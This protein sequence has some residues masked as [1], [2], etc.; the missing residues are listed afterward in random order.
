MGV[1]LVGLSRYSER[2]P[3]LVEFITDRTSAPVV[4]RFLGGDFLQVGFIRR[5]ALQ[6]IWRIRHYDATV[7][8]AFL[9]GLEDPYYEVRSWTAKAICRMSESVGEDE[10]I[11][12]LLRRNLQDRWFEVIVESA[13][14]LGKIACDQGIF[15][16][17]KVLLQHHNW[18]VR[19]AALACLTDL[20]LRNIVRV[21]PELEE[22]L[23]KVQT[24]CL[25]FSPYFPIQKTLKEFQRILYEKKRLTSGTAGREAQ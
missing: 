25:D 18:K 12:S 24:T 2:L 8:S 23:Q 20:L 7:R 22:Y 5:N 10:A 17:A 16:D 1:K 9:C 3:L 11:E 13:K 19:D 4:R 21:S 14:A 15:S 6:A